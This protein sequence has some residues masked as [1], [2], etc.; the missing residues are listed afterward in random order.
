MVEKMNYFCR[1]VDRYDTKE[2]TVYLERGQTY[3]SDDLPDA[4]EVKRLVD[5]GALMDARE[6]EPA[7]APKPKVVP[8][9]ADTGGN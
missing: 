2:K 3:S 4:T 6:L 8:A 1:R 7:K 5:N 9:K